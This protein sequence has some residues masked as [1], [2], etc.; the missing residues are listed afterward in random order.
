MESLLFLLLV[1]LLVSGGVWLVFRSRLEQNAHIAIGVIGIVIV[2]VGYFGV[3]L[4]NRSDTEIWNGEIT[5]KYS[6]H[7]SCEHSYSCNCRTDKKGSTT[8]DTCYLHSYDVDWMLENTAGN[9]IRIRRVDSQGTTEPPRYTQAKVGDPVAQSHEFTNYIKGAEESLFNTRASKKVFLQYASVIPKYPDGIYDYYKL[10]RTLAVGQ[11]PMPDEQLHAWDDQLARM[12]RSLGPRKQ[13]N[14][15]LVLTAIQ[16]PR[17]AEALRVAWLGG[18]KNDVVVVVGTQTY[19]KIDWVRVFSWTDNDTFKIQLAD[20]IQDQGTLNP[21][22][23][24]ALIA[25]WINRDFQRKH[26]KDFGYLAWESM[27]SMTACVIIGVLDL[28]AMFGMVY[29]FLN[30]PLRRQYRY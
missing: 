26:M 25:G 13:V 7:V 2:L 22:D 3:M 16:D 29:V 9:D 12:L 6:E 4:H 14:A 10:H 23:T 30:K 28:V 18:K 27:P 11:V 20:A 24:T 15:I 5:K 21:V 19:P 8:C 1:P 17:F